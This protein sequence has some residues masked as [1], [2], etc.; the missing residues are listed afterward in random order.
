MSYTKTVWVDDSA[1][2]INA[3]NL[4]HIEQGIYDATEA[5]PTE[6]K[7]L[8]GDSTHRLVTD[9]EK[10]SWNNKSEVEWT[11]IQ[12]SGTKVATVSIDGT[13]T[14]V[15]APTGGGGGASSLSQ[16]DDVS[17]SS[18]TNNQVLKYNSTTQKW[19]NGAGGGIRYNKE[20]DWV[21]IEDENGWHDWKSG[22]LLWDGV[23]LNNLGTIQFNDKTGG[24]NAT[25]H[26]NIDFDDG[27]NKVILVN[28]RG[29]GCQNKLPIEIGDRNIFEFTF[30]EFGDCSGINFDLLDE[31]QNLIAHYYKDSSSRNYDHT[32]TLVV[33]PNIHKVFVHIYH[34]DAAGTPQTFVRNMRFYSQA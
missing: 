21:Q 16:L 7:D 11:Q 19:E 3:E 9:S 12:Q 6:L 8:T 25:T 28:T 33:P 23:I 29:Q 20:T 27:G 5:I 24:W 30:Y 34:L 13:S 31:N 32:E 18:P 22:G 17:I 10:S 15:Y 2:D 26:T 1:P 14:D 4:N